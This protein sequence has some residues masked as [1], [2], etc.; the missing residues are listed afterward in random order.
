MKDVEVRRTRHDRIGI[1]GYLAIALGS[2]MVVTG[3]IATAL[4][5]T[6][7][8]PEGVPQW[9]GALGVVLAGL[10]GVVISWVGASALERRMATRYLEDQIRAVSQNLTLATSQVHRALE[11]VESGALNPN[12]GLALVGQALHSVTTQI[13][14]LQQLVGA[15]LDTDEIRDTRTKVSV[16]ATELA[17]AA[18][19]GSSA[20]EEQLSNWSTMLEQ[21]SSRLAKVP[22][23]PSLPPLPVANKS[24]T[25][26]DVRCPECQ[27]Q[28]TIELG[29]RVAST[30]MARCNGCGLSFNVHRRRDGGVLLR[31][32]GLAAATK[33]HQ[34]AGVEQFTTIACIC[35]EDLRLK[36]KRGGN[37][38][39]RPLFCA[40][41]GRSLELDV[42]SLEIKENGI[43]VQHDV[44][45]ERVSKGRPETLC[46]A[47]RNF[48]RLLIRTRVGYAGLCPL[49]RVILRVSEAEYKA[50]LTNA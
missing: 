42:E 31:R 36:L 18:K 39:T 41:C 4:S 3:A 6:A 38:A 35:G 1:V 30:K 37:D 28:V 15:P 50:F 13:S 29:D 11:E 10:G 12:F 2:V 20:S 43:L 5:Q 19:S 24:S 23:T 16:L 8:L 45:I 33:S 7:G 34:A 44:A 21:V 46:P 49:D 32:L 14:E 17:S 27:T 26:V 48:R 22:S 47:C 40:S 25:P 9:A